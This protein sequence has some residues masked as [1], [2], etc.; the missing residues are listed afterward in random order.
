[1]TVTGGLPEIPDCG[2]K[3]SGLWIHD[4]ND[5]TNVIGGS[6]AARDR[7][8]EVNGCSGSAT[9][10]WDGAPGDLADLCEKYTACPAEYPVIFCTTSGRGHDAQ[11]DHALP[12][13]TE[14]ANELDPQ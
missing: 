5:Q 12:A 14:F 13:F 7:V 1:M 9:E 4:S 8:L 2:G 6:Y 3:V 10:K 11:D